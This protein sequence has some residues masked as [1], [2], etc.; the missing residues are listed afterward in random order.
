MS[1]TLDRIARAVGVA[2][3]YLHVWYNGAELSDATPCTLAELGFDDTDTLSM[4]MH[5]TD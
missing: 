5:F 2:R 4:G 1:N 3:P